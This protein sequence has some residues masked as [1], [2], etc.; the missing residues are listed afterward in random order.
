MRLPFNDGWLF[1]E[2]FSEALLKKQASTSHM[3]SVRLPHSVIETPFNYFSEELYQQV[4]IYKK[5]FHVPSDWTNKVIRLQFEAVAHEATVYLNGQLIQTHLGGYTAFGVDLNAYLLYDEINEVVVKVDSRENLNCPPFG[6]VIDYMTYG[7][8]YR[9]V[10]LEVLEQ[11]HIVD[12]FYTSHKLL[13]VQKHLVIQTQLSSAVNKDLHLYQ[14]SIALM[15]E[16]GNHLVQLKQSCDSFEREG[17][18]IVAQLSLPEVI[19]WDIDHPYLY[20]LHVSLFSDHS[21][22]DEHSILCGLREAYFDEHGFWLNGNR[23]K[24][25]GLNRH[26]S[27]PYVGYA[28]PKRPQILDAHIMKQDLGLNAVRTAHYPQSKDFIEACDRLGL[29]V[30]TELPGWQHIGDQAW[31]DNALKQVEEMVLQYR[32][33]P[34]IILW[35]VRV[36]E[37]VDDHVFYQATNALARRLD[38]S[39]PTGGVRNFSHSELFEDVYTYNDFSHNGQNKGTLSKQSVTKAK[40]KAYLITEYNGHM[41]P[42]K[43]FD[44]EAH[45]IDHALRHATVLESIASDDKVAGG[46][47]WC[48]ADYNTHQDFGSGDRICHHGVLDMFRNHKLAAAIYAS[49][50]DGIPVL[51][52]SS[53]MAMGDFPE[54]SLGK[55]YVFSNAEYIHLYR[56]DQFIKRFEPD[57][58]S[59]SHLAHPVF[60]I[61]DIIGSLLETQEGYSQPVAESIKTVL[62]AVATHG[63]SRLPLK[64]KLMALRLMF[65]SGMSFAKAQELY[66]KYIGNWGAKATTYRF[67]AFKN[68]E[69]V[70]SVTKAPMQQFN[71]F[72]SVDTNHL[73]EEG[74]YDVATIRIKAINEHEQ[75]LPYCFDVIELSTEGVIELIGP[76]NVALR[77]GMSGTFVRSIGQAGHGRLY[78]RSRD[79]NKVINFEVKLL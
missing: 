59:F 29:L 33:H 51:Q 54:G 67:D 27:Y 8:I 42:T 5:S 38:P 60:V 62:M 65:F 19:L 39:R 46:F 14:L 22:C 45:R 9:E 63:A 4:S 78:I 11:A 28:M 69:L 47:G 23:I 74:S 24:I 20:R 18:T 37:S 40:D 3:R 30:F 72:I 34:S 13:S 61:D 32:N 25:R 26:Q 6:Y 15:D 17:Q 21:L 64:V 41:F 71:L 66:V 44:S 31:K 53:N 77:G 70:A 75:V 10:Y 1:S 73:V 48:F 49:Q 50:A 16:H 7:G 57:H 68:N 79:I 56:N 43:S 35:G 12:V 55:L 76:K 58:K 52:V 36:N 2:V